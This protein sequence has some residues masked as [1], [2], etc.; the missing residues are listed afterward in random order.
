MKWPLVAFGVIPL[1]LVGAYLLAGFALLLTVGILASA[2]QVWLSHHYAAESHASLAPADGIIFDPASGLLTPQYF[3]MRLEEEARR[4]D[5]YGHTMS[6]VVVK[7]LMKTSVP[8]DW[9]TESALAAHRCATFVRSVDLVSVLAPFEFGICL[10]ES[11]RSASPSVRARLAEALPEYDCIFGIVVYPGDAIS[12]S[13][14]LK[15]ARERCRHLH[16]A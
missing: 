1:L 15:A 12:P 3:E 6:V 8:E 10:I 11:D 14:L 2:F 4:C 5:R 16:P 13:A 7:L 9:R